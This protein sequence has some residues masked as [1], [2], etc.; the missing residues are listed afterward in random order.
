MALSHDGHLIPPPATPLRRINHLHYFAFF[1]FSFIAYENADD[2]QGAN[3]GLPCGLGGFC[4]IWSYKEG[5]S[6]SV[7]ASTVSY[8]CL[9]GFG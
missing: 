7:L 1:F 6:S 4:G 9:S 8:C 3:N 2:G 5:G